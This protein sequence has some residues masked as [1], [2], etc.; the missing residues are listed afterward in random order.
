MYCF[1]T[2][3]M[4]NNGQ[5]EK[6]FSIGNAV[7][8]SAILKIMDLAMKQDPRPFA[9]LAKSKPIAQG[10]EAVA[11]LSQKEFKAGSKPETI[12]LIQAVLYL[13]FDCFD[14]AHQIAQDHEGVIG[15]WIHAIAH[16]REP[17]A[18][19][20]KYWYHR[21]HAPAKVLEAIGGK[22]AALLKKL[23]IPELEPLLKKMEKSKAWEPETFVDLCDR[24]RKKDPQSPA[25]K[26]LAGIQEIE[27]R[28]LAEY[29]LSA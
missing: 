4:E 22:A 1:I 15:N 8:S 14:E 10:R 23:M 13:C 28:G 17:D 19:N 20:A 3:P 29:I 6:S 9:R 16:R 18:S 5:E 12:L 27:W 2:G 25:Y 26:A 24:F 21:V 11:A 7:Q